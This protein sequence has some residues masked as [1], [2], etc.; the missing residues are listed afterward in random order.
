M[1]YKIIHR[2]PVDGNTLITVEGNIK[3]IKIGD[4]INNG[5][6]ILLSVAMSDGTECIRDKEIISL[7]VSGDF[8]ESELI[9]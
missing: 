8:A 1:G 5:K 4:S 7:L 3:P 2:M 6:S 9:Y